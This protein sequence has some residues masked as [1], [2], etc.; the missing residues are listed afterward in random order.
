MFESVIDGIEYLYESLESIA[1]GL[2]IFFD[3][4]GDFVS[5]IFS[6]IKIAIDFISH[7]PQYCLWIPEEAAVIALTL[8]SFVAFLSLKG[9]YSK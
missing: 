4:L 1:D 3:Y 2:S 8:F 9:F 7:F 6:A 5:F